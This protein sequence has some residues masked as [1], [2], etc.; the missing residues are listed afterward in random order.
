MPL[1]VGKKD[2]LDE[3]RRDRDGGESKAVDVMS[4]PAAELALWG[5]GEVEQS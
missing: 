3:G 4:G 2:V 1:R 5:R